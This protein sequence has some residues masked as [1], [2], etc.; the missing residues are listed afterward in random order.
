MRASSASQ[1][2]RSGF[3]KFDRGILTDGGLTEPGMV[4][5]AIFFG[6]DASA[7]GV[8]R[9]FLEEERAVPL[10]RAIGDRTSSSA[11]AARSGVDGPDMVLTIPR[12]K[13]LRGVRTWPQ[14]KR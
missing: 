5:I 14:L 2:R 7:V 12:R 8:I 4:I 6:D 3:G 10:L 1:N 9:R 11:A 13:F